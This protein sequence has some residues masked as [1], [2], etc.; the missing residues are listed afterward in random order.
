MAMAMP[1]PARPAISNWIKKLPEPGSRYIRIIFSP[2]APFG[3]CEMY[4]QGKLRPVGFIKDSV[5]VTSSRTLQNPES[6]WKY[7]DFP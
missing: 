1:A 3:T 5:I 6:C 7:M 4:R 2:L